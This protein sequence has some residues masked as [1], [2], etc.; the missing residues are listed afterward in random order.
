MAGT[1]GLEPAASAVTGQRS[2]QLNYVPFTFRAI[3]PESTQNICPCSR[4]LNLSRPNSNLYRCSA[5]PNDPNVK[6][7][8][9]IAFATESTAA[10]GLAIAGSLARDFNHA[11]FRRL[12]PCPRTTA[13]PHFR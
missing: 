2:N 3:E 11:R 9:K 4:P 10:I 1:T 12:T 8:E 5:R 13:T 7:T 6:R